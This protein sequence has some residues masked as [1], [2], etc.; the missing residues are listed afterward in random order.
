MRTI[1]R[2]TPSKIMCVQ[3]RDVVQHGTTAPKI[4]SYASKFDNRRPSRV[5]S[6]TTEQIAQE[7][8]Q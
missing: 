8:N 5:V 1:Y 4:K 3:V 6:L 7:F 2:K